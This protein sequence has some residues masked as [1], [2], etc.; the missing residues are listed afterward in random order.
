MQAISNAP[1]E[2]HARL[3]RRDFRPA[4]AG[5]LAKPGDARCAAEMAEIVVD[6]QRVDRL[7]LIDLFSAL[8]IIFAFYLHG[9]MVYQIEIVLSPNND[10]LNDD[11]SVVFS[12]DGITIASASVDKKS[13]I[14]LSLD[15]ISSRSVEFDGIN[16][17][18]SSF[19][20]AQV[21]LGW[22]LVD[23]NSVKNLRY[24]LAQSGI[25]EY[26]TK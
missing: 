10:W 9:P 25:L 6:F 5:R 21:L 16:K 24:D 13:E 4:G 1:G 17:A 8:A 15:N 19:K 18:E 20:A 11:C 3:L 2:N 23:R 26:H 22:A 14:Y 12:R 7:S